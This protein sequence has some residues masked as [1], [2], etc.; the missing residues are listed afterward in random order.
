MAGL[1]TEKVAVKKRGLAWCKRSADNIASQLWRPRKRHRA[2]AASWLRQIDT[3][4]LRTCGGGLIECQQARALEGR[5]DPFLWPAR[6]VAPDMGSDGHAGMMAGQRFFHL[7]LDY[8]PDPSHGGHRCLLDG[9]KKSGL[10]AFVATMMVVRA[11][12]HGPWGADE[13]YR[14]AKQALEE[15]LLHCDWEECAFLSEFDGQDVCGQGLTG[16]VWP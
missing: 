16:D 6:S 12:P 15:H 8:T 7:N 4:L 14:Q 13:R 3:F 11:V 10:Y 9:L 2:A 1:A 5:G